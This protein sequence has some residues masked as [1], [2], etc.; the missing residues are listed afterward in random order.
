[1]IA[2]NNQELQLQK[3]RKMLLLMP[4]LIVPALALLFSILGGGNVS[5]TGTKE[6][7]KNNSDEFPTGIIKESNENKIKIV[8]QNAKD[9]ML[10]KQELEKSI[11]NNDFDLKQLSLSTKKD[12]LVNAKLNSAGISNERLREMSNAYQQ[13]IYGNGGNT[14]TDLSLSSTSSNEITPAKKISKQ[15]SLSNTPRQTNYSN[16]SAP[17]SK[18]NITY[19]NDGNGAAGSQSLSNSINNSKKRLAFVRAVIHGDQSI[20]SG[21]LAKIHLLEDVVVDNITIPKN[22][23]IHGQATGSGTERITI[24]INSITLNGEII[25]VEWSVFDTDGNEGL[26]VPGYGKDKQDVRNQTVDDG[27]NEVTNAT[28]SVLANSKVASSGVRLATNLF[29]NK[30]SKKRLPKVDLSSGYQILIR[31]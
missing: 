9:E 19:G 29:R 13:N 14:S 23:I 28:S 6:K 17:R 31:I 7:S 26:H 25:S 3:K 18:F 22:A 20:K 16:T 24:S 8:E 21:T 12:T 5:A 27:A 4:L 15:Q 30:A 2:Q 1:M 10:L 11:D